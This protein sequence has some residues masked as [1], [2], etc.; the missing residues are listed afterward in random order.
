MF[1]AFGPLLVYM[2]TYE[3][4]KGVG[5]NV[6]T[7]SERGRGGSEENKIHVATVGGRSGLTCWGG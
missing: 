1:A 4:L 2:Y 6:E 3:Y 7:E 5:K